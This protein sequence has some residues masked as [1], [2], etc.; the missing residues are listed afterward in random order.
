MMGRV[1]KGHGGVVA[2]VK[3]SAGLAVL[4]LVALLVAVA[5][6]GGDENEA[7]RSGAEPAHKTTEPAEGEQ[8]EEGETEEEREREEAKAREA[9][10]KECSEVGDLDGQ[11]KHKL[12][13]NVPVLDGAHVYESEGPFGKTEQFFAAVDGDV[14]ELVEKRDEAAKKLVAA[15]Y[16][17]DANDDEEG[18]EAEAHLS[19]KRNVD[20]QVLSLCTGKLRVRY[21]VR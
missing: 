14:E 8:G 9:G 15:G 2:M 21:T 1:S 3:K 6:C 5:G 16:K 18:I 17:L 10:G 7:G 19:G 13:S 11:P 20:I 12:P 4:L